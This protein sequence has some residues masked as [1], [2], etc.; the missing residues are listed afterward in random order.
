[1]E[2]RSDKV[3]PKSTHWFISPFYIGADQSG[4]VNMEVT[5]FSDN[6]A[7]PEKQTLVVEMRSEHRSADLKEILKLEHERFRASPEWQ[8]LRRQIKA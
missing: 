1:M 3:Q 5:I 8:K 7:E 2:A 4:D 6:L